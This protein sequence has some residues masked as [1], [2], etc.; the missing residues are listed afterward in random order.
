[1]AGMYVT[2]NYENFSITDVGR[3]ERRIRKWCNEACMPGKSMLIFD[4]DSL[5][6]GG[7]PEIEVNGITTYYKVVLPN[8]TL[9]YIC[10]AETAMCI[11]HR[12]W[13]NR[14]QSVMYNM[15]LKWDGVELWVCD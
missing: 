9:T 8:I 5:L 14:T 4:K 2:C 11:M 7:E 1:M 10:V 13:E 12:V 6:V 3:F 15:P